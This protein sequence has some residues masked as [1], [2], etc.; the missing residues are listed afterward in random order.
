MKY[1]KY[2]IT[3][4]LI[5]VVTIVWI[6]Y[7]KKNISIVSNE[8]GCDRKLTYAWTGLSEPFILGSAKAPSGI[9]IE[10]L[11]SALKIVDCEAVI[12]DLNTLSW[13]RNLSL[14]SIGKIDLTLQASF[15]KERE[16]YANF[17]SPYRSEYIAIFIRSEDLKYEKFKISKIE[18]LSKYDFLLGVGL[19]NIYGPKVDGVIERMGS[20]IKRNKTVVKNRKALQAK[21]IDGYISYIPTELIKI[22]K[23]KLEDK[24]KILPNSIVKTGDVHLMLSKASTSETTL[25]KIN[26][27]IEKIKENG[28]YD[29]I[30]NHYSKQYQL[31]SV[32]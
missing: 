7:D 25:K 17:S 27:G 30:M 13:K 18:D 32:K 2:I 12:E 3:L 24:I 9:D 10:I 15:S 4:F 28:T 19:S 23:N 21:L 1:L 26:N 20:K 22:K 16:K 29:L 6:Y 31:P 5:A 14:L 8:A 11:N